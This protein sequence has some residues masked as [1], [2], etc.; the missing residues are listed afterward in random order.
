[1]AGFKC[2][3]QITF[4]GYMYRRK[5]VKIG[6]A[7]WPSKAKAVQAITAELTRCVG[8]DLKPKH[9][10][11]Y[12][13]CDPRYN[14]DTFI[15]ST[16]KITT[17]KKGEPVI[18]IDLT[19]KPDRVQITA[20][21]IVDG[22]TNTIKTPPYWQ[23]ALRGSVKHQI[24]S[25]RKKTRLTTCSHCNVSLTPTNTEV[26]HHQPS[27]LSLRKEFTRI[28][29]KERFPDTFKTSGFKE[30]EGKVQTWYCLDETDPISVCWQQFHFYFANLRML[31]QTCNQLPE[32]KQEDNWVAPEGVFLQNLATFLKI[33]CI[34]RRCQDTKK[35]DPGDIP[36]Y[37]LD[38]LW[39]G[40]PS[41]QPSA[42][43]FVEQT[44]ENE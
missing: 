23:E 2:V 31:C 43:A 4:P 17:N 30:Q 37:S 39:T 28:F 9:I 7:E 33:T 29:C 35:V 44:D 11:K 27:F 16:T 8:R 18:Q 38:E 22:A 21:Q 5:P 20:A 15:L 36:D 14:P 10:L 32:N 19:G 25:F 3:K 34:G 40:T 42:D 12:I 6:A 26:D 13:E 24:T 1:M 41:S